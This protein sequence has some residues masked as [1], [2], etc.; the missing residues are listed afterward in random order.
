MRT[1]LR[2][3]FPQRVARAVPFGRL[4]I[5][6][7]LAAVVI[8]LGYVL[9]NTGVRPPFVSDP[10]E[11]EIAFRD[12]S[13]LDEDNRSTVAVA[14]IESGRV[15]EVRLEGEQAVATVE[16]DEEARGRVFADATA[17]IRPIN[18]I[19]QLLVNIDPG[20]PSAGPL[21]EG[22]RIAAE[23][24][25]THVQLDRILEVLDTDTRAFLQIV[26]AEADRALR[27]RGGELR[28][29]LG[30]LGDLTDPA[31]EVTDALADRRRL[32]SRLVEDLDV[33]FA[34]LA[35]RGGRLAEVVAAG[36]ETLAVTGANEQELAAAVRALPATM[37]AAQRALIG[38]RRL[39]RPL[40]P[41]LD[42]LGAAAQPLPETLRETRAFVPDARALLAD[43]DQLTRDGRRPV[44]RLSSVARDL[45][46]TAA[47]ARRPVRR[48][49]DVL[50]A[51]D[52]RKA[53]I[54]QT[55]E[56]VSGVF[57]T[58]DANGVRLRTVNFPEPPRPENF[59][60]PA[61][62]AA[63]RGQSG[64]SELERKLARA[65]EGFCRD[66]VNPLFCAL[67]IQL[68][69]LPDVAALAATD[70]ATALAAKGIAVTAA[71][72]VQR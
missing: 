15:I 8:F 72:E 60:L 22:R 63:A 29:A 26:I 16:L 4:S 27:G 28:S 23:R 37:A 11:L 24:T 14:G 48:L 32:L 34:Q 61:G 35:E 33:V 3:V 19:N 67:R 70:P 25:G 54:T 41:A 52:A 1:L 40:I 47:A 56:L 66:G 58:N 36:Q 6:V 12:A 5:L 51:L 2:F 9:I 53:G 65:L 64:D 13:G 44:R 50:A 38:G 18:A 30:R 71:R 59:G 17:E 62:A 45:E 69:G 31:V 7:Q 49:F 57:S 10:Y 46:P 55:T 68:P 39:S 20:S 42:R 43:I 21:P